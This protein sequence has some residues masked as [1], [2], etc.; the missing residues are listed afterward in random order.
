M[1]VDVIHFFRLQ[2]RIPQ[3]IGHGPGSAVAVCRGCGNVVGVIAHAKADHFAV[4]RRATGFCMFQI[5]QDQ[6]ASPI[7]QHKAV[8]LLVPGAA[9][10]FRLIIA[11]RQ[12]TGGRECRNAGT[13]GGHFGTTGQHH[14]SVA[15]GD[16]AGRIANIVGTGGA[17]GH[18]GDVR[19]FVA[20]P[21]SRIT[22]NHIDHRRRHKERR[23]LA[24]A[25][26][27]HLD[28]V[29]FDV[30]Q[31]ANTGTDGNAHP[32][33]VELVEL[34]QATVVHRLLGGNQAIVNESVKLAGFFGRQPGFDI[35]VLY[36]PADA[37]AIL[38]GIEPV[39]LANATAP[40]THCAPGGTDI[41]PYRGQHPHACNDNPSLAHN[42]THL[43]IPCRF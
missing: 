18:N 13:G 23:Y 37:R 35:Q 31:A 2:A 5:F 34:F 9:G 11:G 40:G 24:G 14:V 36:R 21:D 22:G 10:L 12:G 27:F 26:L 43:N 17:G 41:V 19:A 3:G 6:H 25:G 32:L 29:L 4:N 33:L 39:D 30:L 42:P 28:N 7:T 38:A 1:G 15:I 8:A 16:G 20:K